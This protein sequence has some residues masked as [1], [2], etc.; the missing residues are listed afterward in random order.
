MYLVLFVDLKRE[1]LKATSVQSSIYY[2]LVA[3]L[4]SSCA[5]RKYED[6]ANLKSTFWFLPGLVSQ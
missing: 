2:R 6:Q 1:K 5:I 3:L 4:K